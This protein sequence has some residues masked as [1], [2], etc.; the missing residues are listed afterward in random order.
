MDRYLSDELEHC[1][2]KDMIIGEIAYCTPWGIY[3]ETDRS[4][5]ANGNYDFSR[6]A[7]GTETMKIKRVQEGLLVDKSSIRDERYSPTGPSY[8]GD[9]TPIPVF[10]VSKIKDD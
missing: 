3:A 5:W 4:M 9:F 2:L 6:T 1:G 8:M 10:L 7:G